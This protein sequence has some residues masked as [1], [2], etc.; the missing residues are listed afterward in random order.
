M[1]VGCG[2]PWGIP[3]AFLCEMALLCR[4]FQ[5]VVP[6]GRTVDGVGYLG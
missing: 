5:R 3:V 4:E 2:K 6:R 1:L